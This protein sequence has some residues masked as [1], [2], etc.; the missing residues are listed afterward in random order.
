MNFE[1][2]VEESIFPPETEYIEQR[3][4]EIEQEILF[5]QIRNQSGRPSHLRS[6]L[7]E[8]NSKDSRSL[9]SKA[10]E[11]QNVRLNGINP[12][13]KS[14]NPSEFRSSQNLEL[15]NQSTFNTSS[16]VSNDKAKDSITIETLQYW[17]ER[18]LS[19]EK[20]VLNR[21]REIDRLR[22]V[23]GKLLQRSLA[24]LKAYEQFVED[25]NNKQ[26][27]VEDTPL[28]ARK[29]FHATPNQS[30]QNYIELSN[31]KNTQFHDQ[32]ESLNQ[33]NIS[34]FQRDFQSFQTS[35]K[36]NE[37]FQNENDE[38]TYFQ[39]EIT[40]NET[41]KFQNNSF[42]IRNRI[43]NVRPNLSSVDALEKAQKQL[44]E[45]TKIASELREAAHRL[46][47]EANTSKLVNTQGFNSYSLNSSHINPIHLNTTDLNSIYLKNSQD[48]NLDYLNESN[49]SERRHSLNDN[50]TTSQL[51]NDTRIIRKQGNSIDKLLESRRLSLEK[52]FSSIN[53]PLRDNSFNNNTSLQTNISSS[54]PIQKSNLNSPS[55]TQTTYI[56]PIKTVHISQSFLPVSGTKE[57][58]YNGLKPNT[59]KLLES[60][61][62][63]NENMNEMRKEP[64]LHRPT[65]ALNTP[66]PLNYS[67]SSTMSYNSNRLENGQTTP[68]RSSI[69]NSMTPS[70]KAPQSN[71]IYTSPIRTNSSQSFE[72]FSQSTAQYSP[73]SW[74]QTS[75][76]T[77]KDAAQS[78]TLSSFQSNTV[79]P[80]KRIHLQPKLLDGFSTS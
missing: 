32:E 58:L 8:V 71:T 25:R 4:E 38:E 10:L 52:S 16:Q 62:Q 79:P 54:I 35:S 1:P 65:F 19:A 41:K 22:Q 29:L 48:S 50:L 34:E 53:R 57:S 45:S 21:D 18:A 3:R 66:P 31:N 15:I 23:Q 69:S 7:F 26:S 55:K 61:K 17:K 39:E 12:N 28:P 75:L 33:Y 47:L 11:F 56:E 37:S 67:N 72:S 30:T 78:N 5:D 51:N 40:E 9:D 49:I 24:M 13:M 44:E 59:L 64:D 20:N 43:I 74:N 68:I 76:Y 73:Q 14:I 77:F 36:Y 27:S 70:P 80:S 46:S 42:D 6:S 63:T 60:I 2:Q